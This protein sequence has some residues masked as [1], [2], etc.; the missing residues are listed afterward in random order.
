VSRKSLG[1][2]VI[3][4]A[5]VL[6]VGGCGGDDDDS[7]SAE[8]WASSVCADLSEWIT[9]IDASVKSVTD[10][11]L[12]INEDTL[13]EAVDEARTATDQV[14]EDLDQ[15]EAPDTDAGEQAKEELDNLREELREQADA[16]E[17]AVEGDGG[18]LEVAGTVAAALSTAINQL[19]ESFENLQGVD[20]GG[21]IEDAFRNSDECD[22]LRE[23]IEDIR[24]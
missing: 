6:A 12:G 10:E 21:E 20:P 13:R 7:G 4:L 19:K 8:T 5:L 15:L 18:P 24:S 11:G 23:Q 16:V 1:L 3:A 22:S 14:R 9:D 2:L 17:Q